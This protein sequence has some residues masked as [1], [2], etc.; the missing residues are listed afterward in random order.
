MP[1]QRP[2]ENLRFSESL[3]GV[4]RNEVKQVSNSP[5]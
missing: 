2:E 1:V 5:Y 3:Q 4:V